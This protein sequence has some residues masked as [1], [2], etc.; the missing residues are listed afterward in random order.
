MGRS[1]SS[2]ISM[3]AASFALMDVQSALAVEK[4][5]QS[6]EIDLGQMPESAKLERSIEV[7]LD[8]KRIIEDAHF[9]KSCGCLKSVKLVSNGRSVPVDSVHLDLVLR[10]EGKT[11]FNEAV[12]MYP[13]GKGKEA[14][15][16]EIRFKGRVT[17]AFEFLNLPSK[18]IQCILNED[19]LVEFTVKSAAGREIL[20]SSEEPDGLRVTAHDDAGG[21]CR[22]SLVPS[23]KAAGFFFGSVALSD[24]VSTRNIP[25]SW[26]VR[27]PAASVGGVALGVI[28]AGAPAEVKVGLSLPDSVNVKRL[29]LANDVAALGEFKE[30]KQEEGSELFFSIVPRAP[31]R[32]AEQLEIETTDPQATGIITVS[33]TAF[34]IDSS[35]NK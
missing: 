32:L 2:L 12:V 6:A 5:S 9:A 17:P 33:I 23:T 27:H 22:V 19:P 14:E 30:E 26:S 18:Q 34:A 3:V 31:G 35:N 10:T 8:G 25:I 21:S 15:P 13:E 4:P 28:E 20:V 1:A 16:I 24:G 7:P 11:S 29:K